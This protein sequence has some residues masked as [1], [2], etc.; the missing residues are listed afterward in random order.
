M[1]RDPYDSQYDTPEE[2]TPKRREPFD[3]ED[4]GQEAFADERGAG[5]ERRRSD[6]EG[7]GPVYSPDAGGT[8]AEHKSSETA[9]QPGDVLRDR[10]T[11]PGQRGVTEADRPEVARDRSEATG[12]SAEG[13][14]FDQRWSDITAGFVD[15]PRDSVEQAD[16]LVQEALTNLGTR[17][18]HVV[19]RWKNADQLDTE[20]LRL[21]L[22]EYR[23]IFGQLIRK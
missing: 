5:P 17:L 9:G 15:H 16:A 2:P 20:Q 8:P 21:A 23:A 22:Q 18:Q 19:D 7:P 1:N 6:F 14:D 13:I 4:R 10:V 12:R 3:E 11:V